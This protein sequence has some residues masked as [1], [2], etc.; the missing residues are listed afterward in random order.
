[1]RTGPIGAPTFPATVSNWVSSVLWK[2][3]LV[4]LPEVFTSFGLMYVSLGSKEWQ[5]PD[6]DAAGE[7]DRGRIAAAGRHVSA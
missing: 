5:E 2:L 6:R 1:M 3:S 7:A 4:P